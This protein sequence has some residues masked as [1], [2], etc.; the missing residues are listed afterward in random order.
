[1]EGPD[2]FTEA[3]TIRVNGKDSVQ[4]FHYTRKK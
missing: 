4:K 3:W 1:M 2:H